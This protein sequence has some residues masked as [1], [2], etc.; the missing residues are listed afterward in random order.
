VATVVAPALVAAVVP[1]ALVVAAVVG[2]AVVVAVVPPQAVMTRI[3]ERMTRT[4]KIFFIF[5]SNLSD[6]INGP[7]RMIHES[8]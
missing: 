5:S 2:A 7:I 1:A 8:F 6:P 4:D 3:R